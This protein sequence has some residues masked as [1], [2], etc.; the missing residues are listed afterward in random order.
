MAIM[1]GMAFAATVFGNK[2]AKPVYELVRA[3]RRLPP[4]LCGG[5]L[6]VRAGPT[7][8]LGTDS[9]GSR[10]ACMCRKQRRS[11]LCMGAP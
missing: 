5:Q 10:S 6:R 8:E 3:A 7:S 4:L 9:S 2:P 1:E 11:A